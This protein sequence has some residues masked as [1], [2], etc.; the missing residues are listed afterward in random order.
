M[1]APVRPERATILAC[2][3]A[4]GAPLDAVVAGTCSH[5]KRV[6]GNG[7]FDWLVLR[8]QVVQ[9]EE[10]GPMLTTEVEEQGTDLPTVFDPQVQAR[11]GELSRKDPA[12]Q[13]ATFQQRVGLVF[14]EFQAAWAGRD[15]AKMRPYFTD[16]LFDTQRYWVEA[17]RAQGLRN[18]TDR[19]HIEKLELVR[20]ASDKWFDA[21]TVRLHG[22][23]LDYVVRDSDGKVMSGSTQPRAQVHG[24][25]DVHPRRRT[26]RAHAHR[27]RVP[28]L[29]RAPRR[30]LGGRLPVLPGQGHHRRGR[31]GPLSHRA[32]DEAYLTA[33]GVGAGLRA[34][35]ASRT[36][37]RA[38]RAR[39]IVPPP[40]TSNAT[41]DSR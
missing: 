6:V 4:R 34:K 30:R 31:L 16:A 3:G 10:R 13:W 14:G 20:V 18:V 11:V 19:A 9:S 7:A 29:R 39:C 2:P 27:A 32:G 24:V 41:E 8:A 1:R 5:C 25:L 28:E 37:G 23:G 38:V 40:G 15:L 33:D 36:E 22:A 21:I 17:Y 35:S 12:F 26:H